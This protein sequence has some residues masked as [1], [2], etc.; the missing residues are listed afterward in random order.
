MT[1][2]T[3]GL[4]VLTLGW[5]LAACAGGGGA[6]RPPE[7]AYGQDMCD[8]CGM[9]IDDARFA[10]ATLVADGRTHKFDSIG[11]M[12]MYHMDHPDQPVSAWFVHDYNTEAWTRGETASYVLSGQ[13]QAPMGHGL[14]AFEKKA[15][16]D[17]LAARLGT[18]VM[19]FDEVK[20]AVHATLH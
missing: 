4:W 3:L 20:V 15:D 6:T 14:A 12:V 11:D 8:E 5:A 18:S 16:A 9:L 7:I 19:T 2:R 1:L 10:A 17:T 13:I